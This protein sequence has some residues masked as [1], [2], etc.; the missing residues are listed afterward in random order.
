VNDRVAAAGIKSV[1]A[2]GDCL[3]PSTVA[4]AVF[5]GRLYAEEMD[6]EIDPDYV[7]FK[8]EPRILPED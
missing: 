5:A 7:P 4:A 2:A 8:R 3:A 6:E 1:T